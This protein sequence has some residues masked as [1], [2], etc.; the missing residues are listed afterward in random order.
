MSR[1]PFSCLL[2]FPPPFGGVRGLFFHLLPLGRPGGAFVLS[3]SSHRGSRV[4]AFS[5]KSVVKVEK[6]LEEAV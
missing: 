1:W 6:L 2:S 5:R 4:G 3:I